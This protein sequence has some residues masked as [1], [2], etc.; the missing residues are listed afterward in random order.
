[1]KLGF[2]SNNALLKKIEIRPGNEII[3]IRVGKSQDNEVI[4]SNNFISKTHAKLHIDQQGSL[5]IIDLGST[6]GTFINGRRIESNVKIPV[7]PSDTIEFAQ[8]QGVRLVFNPEAYGAPSNIPINQDGN[9]YEGRD[10]ISSANI[11]DKLKSKKQIVIGRNPNCDVVI[12]NPSVSRSHA[13]I[14]KVSDNNYII[15]DLGSLNGTYVNGRKIS[16]SGVKVGTN[17]II[18]IGRFKISLKDGARDLSKEAAIKAEKIVK[19]YS[20]G[21]V[22]LHETSIEIP[23][24]SLLAVMG[25]SG[26]GKSTLLKALNGDSP[27]SQGRVT[28][29]GLELNE[30]YDYIKTHIGYVPQDDIVH[31]ELSVYK[32]LYYAAKLRLSDATNAEIDQKID[33]VL[34]S[35]NITHIK[36]NLVSGISGGQRKRVSIA[37]ELLTDPLVLFLDEPTSPLDPQTI[38][39]F[40]GCLR[41]LAEN[42]T[43]VI[44]V[45][46]K[47]EDLD[48]MDSVIFMAEGGHLVY[49]GTTTGYI[50]HFKQE[51][52]TKVYAE[53]VKENAGPWID[54]YKRQNPPSA[55]APMP[56]Q[57][58]KSTSKINYL[59]QFFWLTKR[60]FNIK[61]NDK[62]NSLFMIGQAPIIA[63]LVVVIFDHIELAVPFLIAVS[64]I[65]FGANNAAREIVGEFPI[66][67]RERM[68]NQDIFIYIFSKITVLGTFATVQAIIFITILYAKFSGSAEVVWNNPVLTCAWMIF[69]SIS[70]TLM[71]LF[72]SAVVNTTEKVMTLVP[73]TLIPQILLGG[74]LSKISSSVVEVLSYITISRW[75]TEG[76]ANIQEKAELPKYII[77]DKNEG[78]KEITDTYMEEFIKEQCKGSKDSLEMDV[79]VEK[80]SSNSLDV[81]E[82]TDAVSKLNENFHSSYA[83]F[84]PNLFST[85]KID[86]IAVSIISLIFFI[87]I[88]WSLKSKDSI[89][90]K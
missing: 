51:R 89:K 33:E 86:F 74:V 17:D 77:V 57:Q 44:M 52:V 49:Y 90:I 53:L 37:V 32:S 60:Y 70:A 5:F 12:A 36:N 85:L 72:L 63:I 1:M 43:T 30:N 4:I 61:L 10:T 54:L 8:G 83:D 84:F 34:A 35:L 3:E 69:L 25:P 59:K 29:C 6:N 38:E 47:P 20:N 67:K 7:S 48:Y 78:N 76:F 27:A 65:W 21:Y 19:K 22:G 56:P 75:G 81:F 62:V 26:C 50:S 87:G 71:G 13:I 23:S 24:K 79:M 46:H 11:L 16:S 73:I 39:D 68:F 88:Y 80:T 2:V 18:I 45:T 64:A 28:I 82:K 66:Y 31:R 41:K 42:G 15:K 40:L 14:E 9:E 58:I 55:Q